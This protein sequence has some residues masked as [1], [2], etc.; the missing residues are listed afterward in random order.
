M[1]WT[2]NEDRTLGL[3]SAT[4]EQRAR[5]LRAAE[6]LRDC[7]DDSAGPAGAELVRALTAGRVRA[8][9]MVDLGRLCHQHD[10]AREPARAVSDQWFG[11]VLPTPRP[12]MD[13]DYFWRVA[14]R[15]DRGDDPAPQG[16][17]R[18]MRFKTF[19]RRNEACDFATGLG[20][21]LVSITESQGNAMLQ[22]T[23]TLWFWDDGRS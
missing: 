10:E 18:I 5:A 22:T 15:V 20:D 21:R 2:A 13:Q 12:G 14:R 16:D 23:T 1:Q 4:P 17:K 11:L 3:V 8:S 7:G 9:T 6:A 19:S